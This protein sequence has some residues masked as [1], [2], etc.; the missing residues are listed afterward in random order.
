[1]YM[2][3]KNNKPLYKENTAHHQEGLLALFVNTWKVNIFLKGAAS[4]P[5]NLSPRIVRMVLY[6]GTVPLANVGRPSSPGS[7]AHTAL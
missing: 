5:P 3:F 6:R 2:A 1:M 4:C 7:K